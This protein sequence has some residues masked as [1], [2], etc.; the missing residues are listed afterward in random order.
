[1]NNGSWEKIYNEQGIVQHEILNTVVEAIELFKSKKYKYIFDLGCGTGRNT[2][3]L[4]SKGF[5]VLA[6][7]IS[8]KGLDITKEEVNKHNLSDKVTYDTQDMFDM[9][10]PNNNFDAVL[11]V[12][13]QGHGL[14]HQIQKSINE[15]YRILKMGGMTVMDFVTVDDNTFGLGK[16]IAPNTFVG[17]RPGEEDIPHYYATMDDLKKMFSKYSNV[18]YIDRTYEFKDNNGKEHIIEAIVVHAEK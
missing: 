16:K 11:C 12:W 5:Q 8:K 2:V 9:A 18:K 3:Y 6:S 4:A 7:D 1:M 15:V 10:L 14:K 17:G 13:T